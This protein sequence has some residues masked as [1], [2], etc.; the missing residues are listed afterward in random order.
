MLYFSLLFAVLF[1]FWLLLS[2]FW[3]NGL[4]LGLGLASSLFVAWIGTRLQSPEQENGYSLGMLLRLPRYLVWLVVAIVK[5]NIDVVRRVWD[6]LNQP[7]TPVMGRLPV[8]QRTSLC[9]TIYANSI[10][11][12]PGTVAIEVSD[13]DVQV[14]A[15]TRDAF[16]DLA[17]G[18]MDREVSRL[19]VGAGHRRS[20]PNGKGQA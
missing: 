3:D 5:S 7:I 1:G 12:T 9:K 10:T 16:A 17:G 2:G 6:P 18:E 15:L 14:H 20:S 13:T 8:S 4:L 19:E 11:L